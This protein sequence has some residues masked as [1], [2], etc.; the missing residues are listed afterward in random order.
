MSLPELGEEIR[1]RLGVLAREVKVAKGF[2]E[3]VTG[4]ET[5]REVAKTLK[6]MGFDHVKS[7]TAVDYPKEGKI[8]VTYHA[9]SFLNEELSRFMVGLSVDLPRDKPVVETLYPIWNS[10][11]FMEREVYEFFGVIFEGHPDLRPLLLAPDLA[12]KKVMRKDFVVREE[13]IYEGVPH[14]Y[15]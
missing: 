4:R 14:E 10:V 15:K 2:V 7:V 6:E 1:V 5:L 9:S 12:E 8:R 3:V 13:S 11:E